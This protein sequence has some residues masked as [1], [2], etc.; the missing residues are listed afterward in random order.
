MTGTLVAVCVFRQFHFVPSL[1]AD[2]A[3]DK[4]PVDG[5][6]RIER[7]GVEGDT[8]VDPTSGADRALYAYAREEAAYWAGELGREIPPGGF[9]ENLAVRGIQVTD[10]VIGEQWRIGHDQPGR[11]AVLAEVTAPRI[12]CQ[13]FQFWMG[14]PRWIKRFTARGD[15]GSYLRIRQPGVIQ[16]GN[17]VQVIHRPAH[18]VTIRD[19]FTARQQDPAHLRRL[20]DADL[21]LADRTLDLVNKALQASGK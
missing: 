4:G 9:G 1:G 20:L 13:R 19:V 15:V 7:T 10:A 5:P 14:E 12:P 18:G 16:A 3:I 6:V 21:Q 8:R 17:P 2:T 11:P